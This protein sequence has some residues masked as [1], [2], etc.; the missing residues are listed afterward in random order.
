MRVCFIC[1]FKSRR[2]VLY[3]FE[4]PFPRIEFACERCFKMDYLWFPCKRWKEPKIV[5]NLPLDKWMR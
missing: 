1:G 4:K 3:G 2:G 5:V